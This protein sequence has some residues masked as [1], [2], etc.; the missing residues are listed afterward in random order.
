MNQ[1]FNETHF[2]CALGQSNSGSRGPSWIG[3][4]L[5][6]I[7][8]RQKKDTTVFRNS[9]EMKGKCFQLQNQNQIYR[10]E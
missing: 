5:V 4:D 6:F 3:T 7:W 10:V 8:I 9:V 2:C 1:I